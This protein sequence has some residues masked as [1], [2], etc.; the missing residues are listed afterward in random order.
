ML[1]DRFNSWN[2]MKKALTGE[3]EIDFNQVI[4]ETPIVSFM[5]AAFEWENMTYKFLPYYY[6]DKAQHPVIREI[7]D[8]DP[9]FMAALRAGYARVIVPASY[10]FEK[11]V[12]HFI[13]TGQVWNGGDLPVLDDPL[14]Q[15][16]V[17]DIK[18]EEY[19]NL[20]TPEGDPWETKLPTTLVW[21]QN[22]QTDGQLPII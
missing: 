13:K 22:D 1:L 10:G 15:S 18:G 5:N 7:T 3:P 12:L 19:D 16:I 11:A 17:D 14:F 9:K 6:G 8:T 2:A 4:N 21:L 20:G